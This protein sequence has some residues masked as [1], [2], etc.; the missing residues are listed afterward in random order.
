MKQYISN[1]DLALFKQ[2][3]LPTHKKS[4]SS[5]MQILQESQHRFGCVPVEM[6]KLISEYLN[7]STANINGVVSF[8]SMFSMKPNGKY[9]I[10]VCLGTACYIKG[11]ER[12][13]ERFQEQLNIKLG[14]TT[15]DELHSLVPTR[16]VGFCSK[17]P[18][19]MVND[20]IHEKVT[21]DEI[22]KILK[23]LK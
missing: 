11:G 7:I 23:E 10:G 5:L 14:E 12:L 1:E 8:Y 6:Q 2:N 16:C 15:E 4:Q 3:V 21:S 17:A 9:S 22:P 13:L 18:V 20:V 19:V